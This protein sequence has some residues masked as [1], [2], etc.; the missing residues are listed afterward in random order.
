MTEELVDELIRN[1]MTRM[2][3]NCNNLPGSSPD[4]IA[5]PAT[6]SSLAQGILPSDGEASFGLSP[7]IPQFD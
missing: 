4:G 3:E 1:E 2:R 6:A 7:E 5:P